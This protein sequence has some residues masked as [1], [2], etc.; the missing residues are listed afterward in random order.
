MSDSAHTSPE[1]SRRSATR[2]LLRSHDDVG[3][4]FGPTRARST[5]VASA[6]R[7]S[8]REVRG[9][10]SSLETLAGHWWL[11]LEAAQA[12]LHSAA[13]YL[14]GQELA[15]RSR[16]LAEE[17]NDAIRLLQRLEQDWQASTPLLAS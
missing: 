17:R 10:A 1:R 15:E 8:P 13:L 5:I 12:A 2:W 6:A 14:G 16:R 3:D 4:S 9:H 7:P 11:A